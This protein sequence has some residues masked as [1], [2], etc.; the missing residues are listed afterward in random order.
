MRC[1]YCEESEQIRKE[2]EEEER[3]A[4]RKAMREKREAEYRA[5]EDDRYHFTP[6]LMQVPYTSHKFAKAGKGYFSSFWRY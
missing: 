5:R 6:A 4:K 1:I 2:R 3:R